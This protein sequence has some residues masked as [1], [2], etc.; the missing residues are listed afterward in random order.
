MHDRGNHGNWEHDLLRLRDGCG[1]VVVGRQW[2][3]ADLNISRR[4]GIHMQLLDT[5]T[6][7]RDFDRKRGN[8]LDTAPILLVG[9]MY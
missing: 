6:K 2:E 9:R 1:E 3:D 5:R 8:R 4:K 7:Q